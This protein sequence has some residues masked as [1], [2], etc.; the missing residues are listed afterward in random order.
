MKTARLFRQDLSQAVR[1][2][3]EF[4][5]VQTAFLL[6]RLGNGV[7]LLPSPLKWDALIHSVDEFSVDFM[8]HRD[9]PPNQRRT[10][11]FQ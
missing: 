6:K 8:A 3:F 2:P 10:E 1:L 11:L 5:S 4:A 7:L 9:Q